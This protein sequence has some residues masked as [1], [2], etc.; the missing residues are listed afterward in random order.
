MIA[1]MVAW[2][3]EMGSPSAEDTINQIAV[4]IN[5]VN[6]TAFVTEKDNKSL[7][8]VLLTAVPNKNAPK[9]A[10]IVARRSNSLIVTV[11]EPYKVAIVSSFEPIPKLMTMEI[12]KKIMIIYNKTIFPSTRVS[13]AWIFYY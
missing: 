9:I 10:K 11:L 7:P 2:V 13:S 5:M 1:P 4:D 8:I 3:V 12:A 6:T